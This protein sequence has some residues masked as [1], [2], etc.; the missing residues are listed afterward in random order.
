VHTFQELGDEH[1]AMVA[2]F[3]LAWMCEELGDKRRAADLHEQN[4]LQAREVANPRIEALSLTALADRKAL[5]GEIRE[6]LSMLHDAYL[7][8]REVGDRVEAADILSRFASILASTGRVATAARLLSCNQVEREQFGGTR[9]WV[10][11]RNDETLAL[12]RAQLDNDAFDEAWEEGK[13]LSVEEAVALA[14]ACDHDD[15]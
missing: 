4:L 14:V 6:A 15:R 11:S 2:T 13:H 12:I 9:F 7:I 5:P 8:V 3:N 10:T 1:L